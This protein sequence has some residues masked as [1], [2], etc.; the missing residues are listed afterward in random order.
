MQEVSRLCLYP[1][2]YLTW[3]YTFHLFI[4]EQLVFDKD[5]IDVIFAEDLSGLRLRTAVL[6]YNSCEYT[7]NGVE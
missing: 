1:L 2:A 7:C 4:R 6:L 3:V 5:G